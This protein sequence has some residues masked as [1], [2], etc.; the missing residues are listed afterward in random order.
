M[1]NLSRPRRA[2]AALAL[3]FVSACVDRN[4]V[5]PIDVPE[6]RPELTIVAQ[7]RCTVEV[8][9]GAMSCTPVPIPPAPA[10]ARYQIVGGQDSLVKM[11]SY[12]TAWDNGTQILSS[13]V[14]VQN[15][16]QYAMGTTDGTTVSNGGVKVFFIDDPVALGG[17]SVTVT[18]DGTDAFTNA[19]QEY[20]AYN[21]VVQP[22]QIS[23]ARVWQF[24]ISGTVTSF[25]FQVAVSADLQGSLAPGSQLLNAVWD[26]SLSSVWDSAANWSNNAVPGA[27]TV[28]Q[29]AANFSGTMPV[30]TGP[31]QAKDLLVGAATTLNLGNQT[32][33]AGGNVSAYGTVSDGTIRMTGASKVLNGNVGALEVTGSVSLQGATKSTGAVSVTGALSIQSTSDQNRALNISVP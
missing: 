6:P 14:T 29:I 5:A 15:L 16:M 18:G 17:G 20:Y 25:S 4:P 3:V 19:D 8:R 12:G 11:A 31:A 1:P 24:Q 33:E 26:G 7:I 32:L 22:F 21:Q 2:L 13:N 23:N 30:L 27:T 9:S 28:V 10:G